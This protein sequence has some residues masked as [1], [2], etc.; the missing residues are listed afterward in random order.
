[1]KRRKTIN[2]A[3]NTRLAIDDIVQVTIESRTEPLDFW[4]WRSP[5]VT[6]VDYVP[7]QIEVRIW[8][9]DGF[10]LTLETGDPHDA[11]LQALLVAREKINENARRY[12]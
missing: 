5:N 4:S 9:K 1:M 12:L 2:I 11:R 6:R 10:N 3:P 8:L 7:V